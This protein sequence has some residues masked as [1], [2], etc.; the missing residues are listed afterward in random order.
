VRLGFDPARAFLFG[1]DG[2]RVAM[3]RVRKGVAE[4]V[5]G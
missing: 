3:R 4:L 2:K 5:G 1:P